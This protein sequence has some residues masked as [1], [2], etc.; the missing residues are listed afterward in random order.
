L[1]ELSFLV[2]KGNKL[3]GK[4]YTL[5]NDIALNATDQT[6]WQLPDANPNEWVAIGDSATPFQGTFDG[7]GFTVRGVYT[8]DAGKNYQGLFGCVNN[9]GVIRKLRVAE[10]YI[11]GNSYVGGLVGSDS[12]TIID[13][14]STATVVGSGSNVGGLVGILK[15]R[16]VIADSYATGD[17]SGRDS[18]GGLAGSSANDTIRGGYATGNV[19]GVGGYVGGLVGVSSGYIINAYATGSVTTGGNYVGG[20]VGYSSGNILNSYAIGLVSGRSHLG[21]LAGAKIGASIKN[22]YAAG[23]ILRIDTT[24]KTFGGLVGSDSG[25]TITYGYYDR[26]ASGAKGVGIPKSS[27]YMLS[28]EFAG[29]LNV[30]AY[31]LKNNTYKEGANKWFFSTGQYPKL[32]MD[33]VTAAVFANCFARGNGKEGT[34]Y[35]IEEPQHLQNLAVYVNCGADLSKDGF[36]KLGKDIMLNDTTVTNWWSWKSG[37]TVLNEWTAIGQQPRDTLNQPRVRFNGTFDGDGHVVVGVY[38]SKGS[39]STFSGRYQGLFGRVEREATQG[40]V[41]KNVGVVN[42]YI[43]GYCFVGGLVGWNN[44]GMI[45]KSFVKN[46]NIEATGGINGAGAIGGLAGLNGGAGTII[47]SYSTAS[48]SGEINMAGGL[49]GWNAAGSRVAYSYATGD[50]SVIGDDVGGLVGRN[51]GSAVRDCYA[52]GE[53]SGTGDAVSGRGGNVIG[54]LVGMN[55]NATVSRCY[56][57]GKVNGNSSVGGLVGSRLSG[58]KIDSSYYKVNSNTII[59]DHGTPKTDEQMRADT[60]TYKGWNFTTVW[61]RDPVSD[62]YPYLGMVRA[63]TPVIN[64]QPVGG[65]IAMGDRYTL[66][67]AATVSGG[68]ISYQWFGNTESLNSDGVKI[69]G[70]TE[71]AYV[72]P[73]DREML[74]YYYVVVTNTANITVA[75]SLAG[76]NVASLASDAVKIRVG[77]YPDAVSSPDR[78]I[79]DLSSGN[80]S[81]SVSP[82][83]A[84]TTELTAGPNPVD[85]SSGTVSFF[86]KGKQLESANLLIYDAF[87]NVVNRVKEGSW[88]LTDEKG[89]PVSKGTYLV[90]G[91][92]AGKDGKREKVSAVVGVK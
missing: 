49:L 41:I 37:D 21:G 6:G 14:Y 72:P 48:V 77:N 11:K 64:R 82:P 29:L 24:V 60:A 17:V 5:V 34:P 87:G 7:G 79:P 50:V 4:V 32:S 26:D 22:C 70:A 20:L 61:A 15:N 89:R 78:V 28:Q 40:G 44:K 63:Q 88:N 91:V 62:S 31:A 90:R 67:V 65:Q 3:T 68:V 10:S 38:I 86:R 35:I 73:T 13:C 74:R 23:E 69:E 45:I 19:S 71:A 51:D 83:P 2:K 59:N 16:G 84:L 75:D 76:M 25:A 33:S 81:A 30:A 8:T 53:I 36:F 85:K 46:A 39:D 57:I 92:V 42:S 80:E 43:N 47:N 66:S 9:R 27:V 12:G 56:A 52:T 18:V 58:G 54:G 55:F 1:A